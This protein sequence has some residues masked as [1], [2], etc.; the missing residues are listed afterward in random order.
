MW[1]AVANKQADTGGSHPTLLQPT[2]TW[3]RAL[4][5][6][7]DD[8]SNNGSSAP[9][10]EL[11][12]LRVPAGLAATSLVCEFG[13]SLL[14]SDVA[15][16]DYPL[17]AR[18][19][20][21]TGTKV[22]V[23]SNK[24]A[25]VL[26]RAMEHRVAFVD[27]GP[28][29]GEP[30]RQIG[31][32]T[33]PLYGAAICAQVHML[34]LARAA[35]SVVVL[36]QQLPQLVA[37]VSSMLK[38][39]MPRVRSGT[40][41]PWRT[42]GN[43]NTPS[44][45]SSPSAPKSIVSDVKEKARDIAAVADVSLSVPSN[46]RTTD[47]ADST[48][49]SAKDEREMKDADAA[50]SQQQQQERAARKEAKRNQMMRAQSEQHQGEQSASQPKT[51]SKDGAQAPQPPE[52]LAHAQ[53]PPASPSSAT[54]AA[55]AARSQQKQQER[56]ARKAAKRA[57]M[58]GAQSKSVRQQSSQAAASDA[59]SEK[60]RASPNPSPNE[61][62]SEEIKASDAARSQSK[63]QE[64][65]ARKEAKRAQME[66]AQQAKKAAA[67]A[68]EASRNLPRMDG[69]LHQS[70]VA[71][72]SPLATSPMPRAHSARAAE[73]KRNEDQKEMMQQQTRKVPAADWRALRAELQR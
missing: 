27:F 66:Q 67:A 73:E 19:E 71:S 69:E 36:N 28:T 49:A 4:M 21:E 6:P 17:L 25:H 59:P 52:Q 9:V 54:K 42:L 29:T 8:S 10:A 56:A 20:Q 62:P 45:R 57:Q 58:Q 37:S 7:L 48:R 15:G 70:S 41:L 18:V 40:L 44:P 65:A 72:P 3:I 39:G 30:K 53:Q 11:L 46:P 55:D 26:R 13:S 47:G 5:Q 2:E 51:I 43:G 12:Q 50:R 68:E 38:R 35:A 32:Q 22:H 1:R 24:L 61:A 64:R 31:C 16:F 33:V 60:P 14:T 34:W 63:Q 23:Y